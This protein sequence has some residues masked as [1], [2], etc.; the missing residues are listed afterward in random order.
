MVQRAAGAALARGLGPRHLAATHALHGGRVCGR[1]LCGA[2]RGAALCEQMGLGSV[3]GRAGAPRR[4]SGGGLD[5]RVV[6][7][8]AQ[9][10]R[11]G[12]ESD[13]QRAP[14]LRA[15]RL[16]AVLLCPCLATPAAIACPCTCSCG[17]DREIK[18]ELARASERERARVRARVSVRERES[19]CS[20]APAPAL[21]PAA[22]ASSCRVSII[23]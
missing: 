14:Q 6:A 19:V 17:R 10:A 23:V 1:G 11:R 20:T 5:S 3:G 18:R 8:G 12:E 7:A 16:H 21:Q 2:R 4:S 9:H 13:D 22:S 15:I